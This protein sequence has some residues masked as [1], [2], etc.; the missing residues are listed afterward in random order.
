[1][2]K[3]S[4]FVEKFTQNILSQKMADKSCVIL[5]DKSENYYKQFYDYENFLI[6]AQRKYEN[7]VKQ[8][9]QKSAIS[10]LFQLATINIEKH[11]NEDNIIELFK[12]LK[13]RFGGHE[14][15][16]LTIYK[17][18]GYFFKDGLNF[19]PNKNILKIKGEWF[20]CEDKTNIKDKDLIKI[21]DLE[22]YEKIIIPQASVVFSMF[23]FSLGKNARM[24]KK[25]MVERLKIVANNLKMPYSTKN[26]S[27][28]FLLSKEE[29]L[30]DLNNKIFKKNSQ[31]L[32]LKNQISIKELELEEFSSKITS[33]KFLLNDY[34]NK[35]LQ[36][37]TLLEDLSSQIFLQEE[38][39]SD[40][41]NK[42]SEKN[43]F[44]KNLDLQINHKQT[45]LEDLENEL[46]NKRIK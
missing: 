7:T 17:D 1:M 33:K 42:I 25:D 45:I 14:L 39:L 46:Y 10:N 30:K 12:E 29:E 38:N 31:L 8:R 36:K 37:E 32:E 43:L 13:N 41:L 24:Q 23:D 4:F 19:Y 2:I 26:N 15:I 27:S 9:M 21:E 44:I 3:A 16:S 11:H 28:D 5:D 34:T 22:S 6:Q 40:I 20:I 18:K 35:I